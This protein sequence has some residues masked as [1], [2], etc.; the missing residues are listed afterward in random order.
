MKN[1]NFLKSIL[2]V[3]L[4]LFGLFFSIFV[5]I[6][7]L[8][9]SWVLGFLI[10]SGISYLNFWL[11]ISFNKR[12][13]TFLNTKRKAFKWVFIYYNFFFVLQGLIIIGILFINSFANNFI[14]FQNRNLKIALAPINIFTCIFGLSLIMIS[15]FIINIVSQKKSLKNSSNQLNGRNKNGK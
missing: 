4:V 9:Y 11:K 13:F 1:E 15:T 14:F 2:K 3:S 6:S 8:N 5:I 7:F 12:F 10:G